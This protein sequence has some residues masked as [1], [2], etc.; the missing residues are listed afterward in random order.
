M[1]SRAGFTSTANTFFADMLHNRLVDET[2]I[3]TAKDWIKAL[4]ANGATH[5]LW[6]SIP[7]RNGGAGGPPLQ[8]LPAESENLP[9]L[10]SESRGYR[11]YEIT[12]SDTGI[13]P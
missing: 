12:A 13:T 1:A 3:R 7:E 5:V 2:K 4:R 11:I 6:N 10:I 8:L 9:R